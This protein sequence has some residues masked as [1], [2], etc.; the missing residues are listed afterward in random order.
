[1]NACDDA[2]SAEQNEAAEDD[3]HAVTPIDPASQ[4][5]EADRGDSDHRNYGRDSSKESPL[6]PV[7]RR[8]EHSRARGIRIAILS[9]R[10]RNDEQGCDRTD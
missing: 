10:W 7:D 1:M 2:C 5:H 9:L 6:K 3:G 8:D 4:H